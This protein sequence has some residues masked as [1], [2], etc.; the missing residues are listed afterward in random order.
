M[1]NHKK[2]RTLEY[3]DSCERAIATMTATE[4]IEQYEHIQLLKKL[5]IFQF[6]GVWTNEHPQIGIDNG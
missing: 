4:G 2:E 5:F 6:T 3:E 1:G